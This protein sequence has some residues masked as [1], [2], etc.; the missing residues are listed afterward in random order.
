MSAHPTRR[1]ASCD[2]GPEHLDP[3]H[4]V[5]DVVEAECDRCHH[6][7]RYLWPAPEPCALCPQMIHDGDARTDTEDGVAH[8]DCAE[9]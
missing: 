7:D 6:R 1:C 2:A 8:E 3:K 5:G 9:L 4:T